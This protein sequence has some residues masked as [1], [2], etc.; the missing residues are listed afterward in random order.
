MTNLDED[1]IN[2]VEYLHVNALPMWVYYI[3]LRCE[4]LLTA[5]WFWR[6]RS[7]FWNSFFIFIV[8]VWWAT[9]SPTQNL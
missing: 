2:F 9:S 8:F 5:S 3:F 6:E 4:N 1:N 7:F